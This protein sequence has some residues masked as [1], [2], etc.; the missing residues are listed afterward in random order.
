MT[1]AHPAVLADLPSRPA[2]QVEQQLQEGGCTYTFFMA[3]HA[4]SHSK[5]VRSS[6]WEI[7]KQ[8][9]PAVRQS[10]DE[11]CKQETGAGTTLSVP[12]RSAK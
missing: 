1:Q 4:R 2:P 12:T 3:Q 5:I 10:R 6:C 11:K 8:A 7:N 9:M